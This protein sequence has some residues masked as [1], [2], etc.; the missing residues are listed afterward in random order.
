[1]E[2]T[3][4]GKYIPPQARPSYGIKNFIKTLENDLSEKNIFN[5]EA[6]FKTNPNEDPD[7]DLK[8]YLLCKKFI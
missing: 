7:F 5:L 6:Y 2:H 4:S 8:Y 1:M 3:T